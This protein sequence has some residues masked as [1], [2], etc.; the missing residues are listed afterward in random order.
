MTKLSLNKLLNNQ[1]NLHFQLLSLTKIDHW[2]RLD[3]QMICSI[4]I[5]VSMIEILILLEISKGIGKTII[6]KV[7]RTLVKQIHHRYNQTISVFQ[8]LGRELLQSTNQNI[9]NQVIS[10]KHQPPLL[11]S[12]EF[13]S[14]ILIL[15]PKS[16]PL[17][18]LRTFSIMV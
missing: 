14:L 13:L 3:N 11:A 5:R 4:V 1:P 2:M 9:Y 12:Q 16:M 17:D 18:S 8:M 7:N 15:I 6:T 10:K